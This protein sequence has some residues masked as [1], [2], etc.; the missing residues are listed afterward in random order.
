MTAAQSTEPHASDHEA[1]RRARRLNTIL[2]FLPRRTLSGLGL[3]IALLGQV[4]L[5]VTPINSTVA[6]PSALWLS[7]VGVALFA[8]AQMLPTGS[9]TGSTLPPRGLWIVAGLTGTLIAAL[10]AYLF[11]RHQVTQYVPIISLWLL[12]AGCYVIAFLPSPLTAP[13]V[14]GLWR[15]NAREI[16]AVAAVGALGIGLRFYQLGA[17]PVVINGDEGL[18]GMFAQATSNGSL[19]NPFALWENIGTLYLHL[20]NAALRGLGPSPLSLRLLPAIGGSL[21]IFTTYLFARQIGGRRVAVLAAALIAMSHIHI[22]FSRTAAVTYI[23]GTWMAPLQLYL[24]L[25]GMLKRSAWRGALAGVLLAIDLNIYLTAQITIGIMLVYT[26]TTALWLRTEFRAGWRTLAAFWGGLAIT[27]I[28][29]L[30]YMIRQP[31]EFLSRLNAD[32]TFHSGWLTTEIQVTGKPMILI[33]VERVAHAF[34]AL[35]YYPALDFYGSPVPGLSFISAVFFLLGLGYM[36]L[37]VRSVSGLLLNGYFWGMTVAIGVFA[38]PPAADSYRMIIALPAAV[39]LAAIGLDRFLMQVGIS[40]RA[41]PFRYT[42]IVS[43]V[44]AGLL[45]FNI[46]TYFFDFV[47]RCRYGGDSQTR[48]ASYLGHAVRGVNTEG[49]VHLLSDATYFYGSHASVDFL[50]QSRTISNQNLPIDQLDI[51]SGET[52]IAS[53]TRID[54]LLGWARSHP[55]GDLHYQRDCGNMILLSYTLP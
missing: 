43:V 20:I 47:G 51:V 40:W 15:A 8:L 27:V 50:T 42:A 4:W 22:H 2:T 10:A 55:G 36:L 18:I 53:P 33:L 34:L 24:L 13:D 32:G 48:F 49:A 23:Q 28:P 3:V 44:Y 54:E 12:G 5:Y 11:E 29:Q 52:V 35:I 30:T 37:R 26:V 19:A 9:S 46:W 1:A 16:L 39:T 21:A 7:L 45:V 14:R 41:A 38:I 17:L 31:A 25:S 6:V